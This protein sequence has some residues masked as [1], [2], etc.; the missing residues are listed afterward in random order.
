MRV[1]T[2]LRTLTL[3]GTVTLTML[4]G[5]LAAGAAPVSPTNPPMGP[6]A[7]HPNLTVAP[8]VAGEVIVKDTSD[9]PSCSGY[10]SQTTPPAS[11]RVLITSGTPHIVAVPFMQ[12]VENVLPNE[13]IP[14]WDGEALKAG[15]VA[16]KS[17]GWFWVNHFGGYLNARANCFDVTDDTDFQVYRAGS[18]TQRTNDAVQQSWSVVARDADSHEV[19]Q[20]F[21]ICSLPF[22]SSTQCSVQGPSEKCGQSVNGAQLSQYGS[23]ACAEAGEN[24]TQILRTYYFQNGSTPALELA[25][26]RPRPVSAT[27]AGQVALAGN[28]T[29]VAFRIAGGSVLTARQTSPGSRFGAWTAIHPGPSFLGLPTA[30]TATNGTVVVYARTADGRVLGSGQAGV[31]GAFGGWQTI[32]LGLSTTPTSDLSVILGVRGAIAM[33]TVGGDGNVWGTGQSRAGST[34]ST[35]RAF[36]SGG[37]FT[38]RPAAVFTDS[39]LLVLYA[40]NGSALQGSGQSRPGGPLSAF[41]PIGVGTPSATGDPTAFQANDGTL[42]LVVGGAPGLESGVADSSQPA[43]GTG[44]GSWRPISTTATYVSGP[45]AH[46]FAGGAIVVYLTASDGSVQGAQAAS[47]ASMFSTF[48]PM[49]LGNP[50]ATSA[51]TMVIAANGAIALYAMGSGGYLWGTGQSRPG[52]GFSSWVRIGA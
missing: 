35:W 31:G 37:G 24:Y 1:R 50:G 8:Q 39:Q 41:R 14:S 25:T 23:Q 51:P 38:G 19:R 30:I 45:T 27:T 10:R 48:R 40:R 7:V 17:Y 34:F 13:W 44:F 11:I 21:Y 43:P 49:G 20:T 5:T 33:Y 52:S 16:A 36:S 6:S 46:A 3:I 22:N 29:L 2:R 18:A 9:A 4:G 26:V 32:G 47:P 42:S 15:A 28:G 12:Y